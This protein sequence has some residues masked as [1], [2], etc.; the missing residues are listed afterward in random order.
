MPIAGHNILEL[1]KPLNASLSFPGVPIPRV[2]LAPDSAQ[3]T[4]LDDD[5]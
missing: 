3:V 5:G 2:I 1:T 4:I